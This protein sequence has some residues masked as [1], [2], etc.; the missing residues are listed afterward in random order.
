V[1]KLQIGFNHWT[2]SDGIYKGVLAL[3]L[4]KSVSNISIICLRL[5][6]KSVKL[7]SPKS[8]FFRPPKH[9]E[10]KNFGGVKNE[11]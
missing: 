11:I 1:D 8:L 5:Y 10:K 2:S 4:K 9:L 7:L 6:L 3:F